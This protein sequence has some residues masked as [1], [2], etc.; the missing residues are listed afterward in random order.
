MTNNQYPLDNKLKELRLGLGLR[1]E[2]VAKLLGMDC[3]DRLSHWE[4]GKA[5]PNLVNLFKLSVIYKVDP[6][7]LYEELW[8]KLIAEIPD[9]KPNSNTNKYC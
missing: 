7:M 6:E 4:K 2:D 1:Q 8:R 5:T 9:A 3:S